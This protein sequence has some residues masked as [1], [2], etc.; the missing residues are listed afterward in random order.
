MKWKDGT[1]YKDNF[2]NSILYRK[3][4][5]L[6]LIGKEYEGNFNMNKYWMENRN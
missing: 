6:N 3:V 4:A 5:I 2:G 1:Y